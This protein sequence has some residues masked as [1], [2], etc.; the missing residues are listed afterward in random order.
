MDNLRFILVV[1]LSLVLLMLWQEWEKDY[2][3]S[4]EQA[5]QQEN[6]AAQSV[7][8]PVAPALPETQ[9]RSF[10]DTNTIPSSV[11]ASEEPISVNTDLYQISTDKIMLQHRCPTI[12]NIDIKIFFLQIIKA[13]FFI[14]LFR[15]RNNGSRVCIKNA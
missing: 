12:D 2:G 3:V 9:E 8:V 13:K 14:T 6:G 4:V 7:D 1:A 15:A 10:S 5:I 11:K